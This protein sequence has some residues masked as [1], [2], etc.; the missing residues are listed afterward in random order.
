ML[1]HKKGWTNNSFKIESWEN[2]NELINR[3]KNLERERNHVLQEVFDICAE[4]ESEAEELEKA[5][6]ILKEQMTEFEGIFTTLSKR[7]KDKSTSFFK[8]FTRF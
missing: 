5:L 7:K 4:I 3:L 8:R 6:S 1:Y 2:L